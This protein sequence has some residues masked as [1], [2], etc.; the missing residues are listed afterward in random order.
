MRQHSEKLSI[1]FLLI[2]SRLILGIV[3]PVI[4]I[5]DYPQ[6][7]IIAATLIFI[8]L[9]TDVFDGIIARRM[10]I[11]SESLRVWD[12]NVDQFFWLMIIGSVFYMNYTSV[13]PKL[14]PILLIIAI[15]II[16]YLLSYVKFKKAIATHSIFAKIWT[17]SLLIWII[18]LIVYQTNHSFPICFWI[19][20][21]SRLEIVLIIIV[22]KKW[23]TDVPSIMVVGKI[24]RGEKVNK[25]KWF[26]G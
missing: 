10:G 3:I 22:L 24:N 11:S 4:L 25:N 15:E 9:L 20:L 7:S 26:N 17:I 16:A 19:G 1:P 5:I 12:S 8:G 13:L 2:Y 14:Y 23:A 6:T 18:E 21:I